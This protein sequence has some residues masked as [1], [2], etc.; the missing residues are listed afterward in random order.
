MAYTNFR[1][2]K[3]SAM[4]RERGGKRNRGEGLL[5]IS[6]YLKKKEK[7]KPANS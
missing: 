7:P 6:V 5:A 3:P 4:G 2:V 1:R